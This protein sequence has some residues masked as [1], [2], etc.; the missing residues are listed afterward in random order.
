[1]QDPLTIEVRRI[2]PQDS[3][4]DLTALLHKAYARLAAMGLR[5]VASHQ[6][7]DITRQ[8][9]EQGECYVALAHG[10]LV[11][12]IIFKPTEATAGSSW[13]D[14]PDVASLAQ[15]AVDPAWQSQGLGGR[16][17]TF[18]EARAAQAGARELALDT[19][20][21]A[22]HLIDWYARRGYRFIEYTQWKQ[23]NYRSVVMSLPVVAQPGQPGRPGQPDQ[24]GV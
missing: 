24:P 4:A 17:M 21:Q 18:V 10:A 16:L 2:A 1:M 12:T 13:L 7:V 11:G 22:A 15:F 9:I 14:R 3:L 20:E 6:S 23:V 19:S 8:R 5:Y